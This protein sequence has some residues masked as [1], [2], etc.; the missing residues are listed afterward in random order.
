M[1]NDS[2][3]SWNRYIF[4]YHQHDSIEFQFEG[5]ISLSYLQNWRF[6]LQ[7]FLKYTQLHAVKNTM[8]RSDQNY[9][10]KWTHSVDLILRLFT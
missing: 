5:T 7:I 9:L 4:Y 10:N 1:G 8:I 2:N 6:P 3:L